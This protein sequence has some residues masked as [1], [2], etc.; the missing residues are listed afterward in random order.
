VVVPAAFL[1]FG[2]GYALPYYYYTWEPQLI[3]CCGLVI[4]ELVRRSSPTRAAAAALTIPLAIVGVG[5]IGDVARLEPRDYAAVAQRIRARV[6]T[7]TVAVWGD[8]RPLSTYVRGASYVSN[9]IWVK[10]LSAIVVD[11]THSTRLPNREVAEYVRVHRRDL[12][13]HQFD[14]LRVYVPRSPAVARRLGRSLPP[15]SLAVADPRR[16]VKVRKTMRCM[17]KGGLEPSI[18][19]PIAPAVAIIGV[20][21]RSGNNSVVFQYESRAAARREGPGIDRYFAKA[22][23]GAAHARKGAV[24]AFV[25]E[26][27]AREVRD[28]ESCL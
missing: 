9:P 20:P 13:R 21:L 22:T 19:A 12:V 8:T 24:V 17:A 25:H 10:D 27:S 28:V 6:S 11:P 3:L 14:F 7:G 16:R 4:A 18:R 23:G 26:P 5:T 15:L 2:I 1:A